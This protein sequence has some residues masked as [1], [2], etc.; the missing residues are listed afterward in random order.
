NDAARV[1]LEA[2]L[3]NEDL[4][5]EA[6]AILQEIYEGRGDWEKLI[7]ALEILAEAEADT[8]Q[9]V[10]LLRKVA[11]VA[12]QNLGNLERAFDAQARALKD[13]PSNSETRRELEVLAQEAGA[14]DRLDTVFNEV[15]EGLSDARLA[16]EYWLRLAGIDER[17]GKIDEAANGYAQILSLDPA[18]EE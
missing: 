2:L 10:S 11:R 16:R 8:N 9:R 4:R 3:T 6:A 5:A 7:H 18:D 12:G 14:W 1:A 13:D 15:A 17:L